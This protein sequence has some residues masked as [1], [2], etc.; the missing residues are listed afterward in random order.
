MSGG[1][2]ARG[3]SSPGSKDVEIPPPSLPTTGHRSVNKPVFTAAAGIVVVFAVW[4]LAAP[5]SAET[6]V[7]EVKDFISTWFGWWYFVLQRRIRP[8]G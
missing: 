8:L 7:G 4:A 3:N 1:S 6:V 5:A 2:S